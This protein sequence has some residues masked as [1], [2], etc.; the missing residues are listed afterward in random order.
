M[1]RIAT[2][3]EPTT[4]VSADPQDPNGLRPGDRVTVTP[5]DYGKIGVMGAVVSHSAQHIAI[6]RTDPI[7]GNVVV[8]FPRVGFHVTRA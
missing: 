4:S 8:H 1:I 2:A 5:D 7:A 3:A 6:H